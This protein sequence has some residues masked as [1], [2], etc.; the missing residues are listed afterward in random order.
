MLSVLFVFPCTN[1]HLAHLSW[2]NSIRMS[3]EYCVCMC[4]YM[5]VYVCVC[6]YRDM[7]EVIGHLKFIHFICITQFYS[8]ICPNIRLFLFINEFLGLVWQLTLPLTQRTHKLSDFQR[9]WILGH[10]EGGVS[11]NQITQNLG[12]PLST[13]N[14]VIV[15]FTKR[16]QGIHSFPF[17][18][19]WALR[20]G[21]FELWSS[22]FENSPLQGSRCCRGGP[23]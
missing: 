7:T 3:S 18:S 10:L 21:V 5:C 11:Q 13:V 1:V 15:K 12:I 6:V 19:I 23:S 8:V 16:R 22:P 4:V 14:R 9:G 20:K 2:T 17:W